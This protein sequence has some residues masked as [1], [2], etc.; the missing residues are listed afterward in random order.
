MTN[1]HPVNR[2]LYSSE[3]LF[4]FAKLEM[5]LLELWTQKCEEACFFGGPRTLCKRHQ[6]RIPLTEISIYVN[7][8]MSKA[9]WRLS[10]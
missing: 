8:I 3:L 6:E 2:N 4:I 7:S 10:A 9:G 5:L 1:N